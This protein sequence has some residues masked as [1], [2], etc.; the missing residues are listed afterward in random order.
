MGTDYPSNSF[1]K[2]CRSS[3]AHGVQIQLE[4][5]DGMHHVFQLD[6]AHL[7]AS[8]AA[9]DHAAAF[10]TECFAGIQ[11]ATNHRLA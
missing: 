7:H 11:A 5:W 9:L 3:D 2:R 1:A 6:V 8:R 10:L 4:I